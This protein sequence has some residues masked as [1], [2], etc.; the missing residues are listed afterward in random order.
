[1]LVLKPE[2]QDANGPLTSRLMAQCTGSLRHLLQA[3][4]VVE[5]QPPQVLKTQTKFACTTRMLV[6]GKL[7][8]FM[9][10]PEVRAIMIRFVCVHCKENDINCTKNNFSQQQA[11]QIIAW[12]NELHA[13]VPQSQQMLDGLAGATGTLL[14]DS[15]GT[16]L[17]QKRPWPS[18]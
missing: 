9:T 13:N 10:P 8:I 17:E 7:N 11:R 5:K 15:K 1:M 3:S 12:S 2:D 18:L 14:N 16:C 4:F 6:G